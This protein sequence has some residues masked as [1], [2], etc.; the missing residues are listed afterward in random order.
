MVDMSNRAFARNH[1]EACITYSIYGLK[2]EFIE[3]KMYNSSEGGMYFESDHD[4]HP[5]S[6]IC[7]KITDYSSNDHCPEARDGYRGEVMWCR[8]IFKEDGTSCY[9]VGVRFI[10]NVCDKCGEKVSFTEIHRTE[11]LIFLCPSCLKHLETLPDEKIKE[12]V[13][14]YLLGNVL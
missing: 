6:E 12:T 14:N 1:Y 5:G 4:L 10:V 3:A 8:K 7:I 11:D 13:A 9:G 2:E